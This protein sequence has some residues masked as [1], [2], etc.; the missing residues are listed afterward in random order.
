MR[1]LLRSEPKAEEMVVIWNNTLSVGKE[2]ATSATPVSI[3][4]QY[5][6][7]ESVTFEYKY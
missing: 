2:E 7:V 5:K 4:H 1:S 6:F 3:V